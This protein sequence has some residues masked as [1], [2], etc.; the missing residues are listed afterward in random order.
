MTENRARTNFSALILTEGAPT[1][2][3]KEPLKAAES[4]AGAVLRRARL[5]VRSQQPFP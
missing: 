1:Y 5:N 2:E 4:T 3:Q